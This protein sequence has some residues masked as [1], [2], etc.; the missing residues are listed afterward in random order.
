MRIARDGTW[1]YLGTPIGRPAMVKL[2]SSVLRLEQD[3]SFVLVTP[4][5]KLGI[6][7]EDAPFQAV[8]LLTS[9]HGRGRS[10]AFRLNTDEH[11]LVDGGH[12]LRVMVDSATEEPRPYVHV[13]RGL[14][15]L[16]RRPVF[17]EMVELA[18]VEQGGDAPLGLWSAGLFFTLDGSGAA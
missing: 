2:F 13:R 7:V 9:G 4:V 6:T 5:E 17:Y 18:L 10:L 12:R 1:Y 15:A 8:E 3:G 14:E 11:V 16:I